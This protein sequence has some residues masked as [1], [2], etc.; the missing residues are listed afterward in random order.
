MP[1]SRRTS[2]AV[3]LAA[4]GAGLS[5]GVS[6]LAGYATGLEARI[7]AISAVVAVA[8]GITIV[9]TVAQEVKKNLY[10]LYSRLQN[11]SSS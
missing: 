9:P 4:L 11:F 2:L 6:A 8:S 10:Q 3:A 1:S 5:Q 7:L